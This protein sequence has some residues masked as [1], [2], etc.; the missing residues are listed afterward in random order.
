[1]AKTKKVSLKE[2]FDA[3]NET[4]MQ[5]LKKHMRDWFDSHC[6]EEFI[7]PM[8]F[9]QTYPQFDKYESASFRKPYY[10]IKKKMMNGE[11]CYFLIFNHNRSYRNTNIF[12]LLGA[13]LGEQSAKKMSEIPDAILASIKKRKANALA[14]R[15]TSTPT[16]FA[17]KKLSSDPIPLPHLIYKVHFHENEI[18]NSNNWSGAT[19]NDILKI[20]S[21]QKLKKQMGRY[22]RRM[23][24][25]PLQSL[26]LPFWNEQ[27]QK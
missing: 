18:V 23:T 17:Q 25:K 20:L 7:F 3:G 15:A 11:Y 22:K 1:M 5:L 14:E 26:R 6:G 21:N 12:I 13:G 9:Q 27:N 24:L 10:A 4:I 19:S 16:T 8:M 2:A